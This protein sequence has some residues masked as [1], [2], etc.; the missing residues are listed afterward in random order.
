M[1]AS[2]P[3]RTRPIERL[4]A[5]HRNPVPGRQRLPSWSGPVPLEDLG[6]PCRDRPKHP[7]HPDVAHFERRSRQEMAGERRSFDLASFAR[8]ARSRPSLPYQR[9]NI[10]LSN[11]MTSSIGIGRV[12]VVGSGPAGLVMARELKRL[13]IPF[14]VF[15]KNSGVGGI[16]NPDFPGSPMYD[17]AHFISSKGAPTST[18]SGHP[19]ADGVATYPSQAEVLAYLE[20]F[21]GSEGLLANIHFNSTVERAEPDDSGWLVTVGGAQRHYDALICASGSLWDP[22]YPHLEGQE[23]YTGL[24]RHSVSYRSPEEVRGKRVLVIG[25]GNSGVDIACD[26]TKSASHVSLSLRRGYWFVPKFMGGQPTD[27]FLRQAK[28]LPHW[29][30][31][32]DAA[33]LLKLLVGSPEDY[34]LPA[35]DHA[36]FTSHPIMNSEVLNHLGHGR[37][38]AQ[39][40]VERIVGPRVIFRDGQSAEFDE[41]ILATGYR[42]S[43]PY[44]PDDFLEFDGG[45][46]PNFWMRLIHEGHQG[47]YGLGFLETNSSVYGLFD[48]GAQLIARHILTQFPLEPEPDL[49]GDL[50]RISSSRHVGYVDSRT[51]QSELQRLLAT[52]PAPLAAG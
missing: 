20:A 52:L 27:L 16:W 35:P 45:N 12:C 26:A 41:I 38:K 4:H 5:Q 11:N 43:L 14:D 32:P 44:L 10:K 50:T 2:K 15:E 34:G 30:Q 48:L 17:S 39:S 9:L 24:I 42:A 21:A 47:L 19:F 31:P 18:F 49:S 40:A 13:G 23:T 6:R 37:I 3:L 36:P 1:D 33:E 7:S 8:M 28:A 51:Y 25:S 22:I 29:A 46:R